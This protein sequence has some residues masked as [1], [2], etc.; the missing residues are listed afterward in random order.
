MSDGIV[1]CGWL[2]PE[3]TPGQKVWVHRRTML[4]EDQ[5][6]FASHIKLSESPYMPKDPI[7]DRQFKTLWKKIFGA[8]E[9]FIRRLIKGQL[10]K[11]APYNGIRNK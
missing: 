5:N 2:S 4:P 1:Y 7:G 9:R 11:E 10:G 6:Y 8:P 3:Q